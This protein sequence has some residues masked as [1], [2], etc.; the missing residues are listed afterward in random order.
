VV[1]VL[2]VMNPAFSPARGGET[3]RPL[4]RYHGE[5]LALSGYVNS[6]AR[7]QGTLAAF[8]APMGAGRVVV[9]GF[10]PQHRAQTW[11]TFKLLFGAIF[12]AGERAATT[13][14]LTVDQ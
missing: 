7:L 6:A 10:R 11:A 4:V 1:A 14:R 9:L 3:L 12:H 13:E 5:P 8:E 2:N